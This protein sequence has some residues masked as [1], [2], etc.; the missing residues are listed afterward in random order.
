M[1]EEIAVQY[2]S[3]TEDSLRLVSYGITIAGA[4]VAAIFHKS[5]A[6]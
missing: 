5:D 1:V 3:L 2:V 6:E 4:I